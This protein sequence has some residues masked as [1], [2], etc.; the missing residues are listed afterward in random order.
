MCSKV[1]ASAI[2]LPIA[3]TLLGGCGPTPA[4]EALTRCEAAGDA[5]RV[6]MSELESARAEYEE[7]ANA[8]RQRLIQ[9]T[10]LEHLKAEV[11]RLE[12]EWNKA[13]HE[14]STMRENVLNEIRS[15][16]YFIVGSFDR[17]F[18]SRQEV[19]A[20]RSRA[21]QA[22]DRYESMRQTA[23]DGE[24]EIESVVVAGTE[25]F[26]PRIQRLDRRVSLDDELL[27]DAIREYNALREP[28]G[29]MCSW[30]IE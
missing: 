23:T 11:S 10:G 6:S 5:Y 15:G 1:G 22:R 27:R 20:A 8:L 26:H 3:L 7:A 21:R 12:A 28:G 24:D 14:I 30:F 2:T 4:E 18:E 17:H 29:P 13:E 16:A 19:K 25:H 9:E